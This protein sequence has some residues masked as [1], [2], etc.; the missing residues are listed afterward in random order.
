VAFKLA[1][2]ILEQAEKITNRRKAF[3]YITSGYDFNPFTDARYQALQNQYSQ[4][5]TVEQKQSNGNPMDQLAGAQTGVFRNP[6]E[7]NG[8]QF[9]DAILASELGELV[10][11]ARRANVLFYLVDPRGLIAG[12]DAGINISSE[13]WFEFV[14]TSLS[15]M[16]VLAGETGG[17]CVC[18][19]ND[20]K[21][22]LQR[23]D[24][25]MSDYYIVGYESNNPDPL[26]IE[27]H[28]EIKVLRPGAQKPV[29]ADTYRIKR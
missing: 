27:R 20:I 10:R 8:L 24:N 9:S 13:D 6:F 26:K 16:D 3:I 25:E 14:N 18:R 7:M 1:W 15:S 17:R 12:P 19:T 28:I 23:I 11:R 22:G 4:P 29:Y 5:P 2:E 21:G